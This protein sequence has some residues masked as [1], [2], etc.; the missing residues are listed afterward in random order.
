[1]DYLKSTGSFPNTELLKL[2]EELLTGQFISAIILSHI[3]IENKFNSLTKQLNLS[4]ISCEFHSDTFKILFNIIEQLTTGLSQLNRASIHI[5]TICLRLF[6]THLQ[7]L[8]DLKSN[9]HIDLT[10]YA[11]ADEL[12]KWFDLLLKLTC[13]DNSDEHCMSKEASKALICVIYIQ[14][15]SF[16]ENISSIHQYIIENTNPILVEQCLIEL[17]KNEVL[18]NWIDALRDEN[19]NLTILQS[20][21]SFIDF[22]FSV[23]EKQKSSIRQVLLAFQQLLLSRLINEC[24]TKTLTDTQLQLS[25]LIAQYLNYIF[26]NYTDKISNEEDLFNSILVGLCLMTKINE[27][28]L[29]EVIQPIFTAILP[30]LAEYHLQNPNDEYDKFIISL[31]G[32]MNHILIIGSPQDCLEIKHKDQLKMPIF[33][34][35]Y[36][37]D[38]NDYL[39]NSNLAN[40]SQ[41]RPM[42]EALD[43]KNFLMSI[44]NNIDEGARLLSKLRMFNKNKQRVIQKSIEQQANDAC[45]A[46]FAVY[47]KY[48]RL[49]NLAKYELSRKDQDPPHDQLLSIYDYAN[50]VLTLFS[51]TKARSGDCDELLKHVKMKTLFLL[52]KV[53]E[54]DLIPIIKEDSPS[55]TPNIVPKRNESR[56]Q[57]QRS[58]W[59]KAKH[60]LKLLRHLFQACL[61]FKKL[62]LKKKHADE[63]KY[64]FESLLHTTI[65]NF[66][67]E[68]VSKT[69]STVNNE[70]NQLKIDELEKCLCRQHERALTRLVA[71]RFSKTFVQNV[72]NLKNNDRCL[73]ILSI[74][75][76][77]LIKNDLEW[78]YFNNILASSHQL[79][80]E[81]SNNYSAVI[82]LVLPISLESK[83]ISQKVFYLLNLSYESTDLYHIHQHQ[84]IETLFV[85]F[86]SLIK[87]S[88]QITSSIDLKFISFNWFRLFVLKL[89]E[90]IEI[91]KQKHTFNE[92]LQKQET[93]VFNT[94]I[95]NDLKSLKQIQ[96]KLPENIEE[97]QK[98]SLKYI[99]IDW[100]LHAKE[101]NNTTTISTKSDIE[102]CRNQY[103]ILLLRCGYLY[104][105]VL[106]NCANVDYLKELLHIYYHSPSNP[107]RLLTIKFL[108]YLIPY[109]PDGIDGISRNLIEKFLNDALYL[110]GERNTSL[111]IKV[112]LI[113]MYRNT[114]SIDSSWCIMATEFVINSV[115]S[116]LNLQSIE[117]NDIHQMNKL[118]A[119]LYILGEYIE[120]FRLGSVVRIE[121]DGKLDDESSLGLIIEINSNIKEIE[122]PYMIQYLQTN[123]IEHASIDKLR[124]EIDVSPPNLTNIEDSILDTLGY[125]IQINVSTSESLML[126]Q[127][128]RHTISVL[129][130][131]LTNKKIIETFMNKSYAS[132][133]AKLCTPNLLEN[134][135]QR[136]TG[137]SLYDKQN[138]EKYALILDLHERLKQ[139]VETEKSSMDFDSISKNDQD[140]SSCHI[141]NVGEI[142][143]DPLVV[144]TL[145]MPA[146]KYN[147][148]KPYASETEIAHFKQGRIGYDGI[149][150]VAMP[151]HVVSAEAIQECGTKHR[152]RGRIFPNSDNARTRFPTFIIDNLRLSE[153]NWYYCV[154]LPVGGLVQ[155]GWATNGFSPSSSCGVGDDQYSW[156]YDGSRAV[157]FSEEGFYDQFDGLHWRK[158]DICGCG[159]EINGKNTKI[160]YWLNGKLLGTAFSHDAEIPQS[161]KK[162]NLL[163]NGPA[164]MFFPAVTLQCGG[165]PPRC[166]E[167]IFS[168]EDMQNCPL[169][170]GFKPL[171]LPKH[172]HIENSLVE[173]P[174]SAYLVGENPED[175]LYIPR[176][177]PSITFLRDFVN[178]YHLETIFSLDNHHLIIP[179]NSNG[180][181]L[182][183]TNDDSK[184]LTISFDVELLSLDER[185]NILLF[186]F[187]STEIKVKKSNGKLRCVIIFLAKKCHIKVYINNE[188]RAF[189]D[190]FERDEISKLNLNI[191]PGI[192]AKIQNIAIWKYALSEGDIRRLFTY[193]VSYVAIYYQ[194][195]KE[196]QKQVNTISFAKGQKNFLNEFLIPFNETFKQDVWKKKKKQ[197]DVNESK[198]FKFNDNINYSTIELFGNKTYLVLDKSI[199]QWLE[200]T[201]IL[202]LM[203][204]QWPNSNEKLTLMI[205]TTKSEIYITHEG[206][207]CLE[208]DGTKYES[209]SKVIPGDYFVLFITVQEKSI[210]IYFNEQLEIEMKIDNDEF[211]IKSNSINLFR[212]TDLSK[213]TTNEDKLRISLKSITYL[214]RS[215]SVDQLNSPMLTALPI[216]IIESNLIA[217]GY[218]KSW[219][220]S[221]IKQ[222]KTTNISTVHRILYEQKKQFIK[223]DLE[224]DRKRYFNILSKFNSSM[225]SS[226][227]MNLINSSKFDTKEQIIDIG[228]GIF[229]YCILLQSTENSINDNELILNSDDDCCF[230]FIEDLVTDHDISKWSVDRSSNPCDENNNIYRLLDLNTIEQKQAQVNKNQN[231]T[232]YLRTSIT[233]KEYLTSRIRCEHRLMTIYACDTIINMIKLW[234]YDPSILFPI[235]KFGDHQF[236]VIL[237]KVLHS[238]KTKRDEKSD[239]IHLLINSILK[240]EIKRL[241]EHYD[242]IN[243]DLL[244]SDAPLFYHLQ[245]Y[246]FIQSIEL[247]FKPSLLNEDSDAETSITNE[248]RPDINFILKILDFFIELI[249]D[250][251]LIKQNQF[252][253]IIPILFPIPL[254][255]LMLDLFILVPAHQCK[256]TILRQFSM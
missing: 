30:L 119:S 209:T 169:P 4:S 99:A 29:H 247:L 221:I 165:H 248:Q 210:E 212:E 16:A 37:T 45:A 150:I 117:T 201:I 126:L 158:N 28:F 172:I 222:Y 223:N 123:Q 189:I 26:K 83:D 180:F 105:H 49:I 54:S 162:C 142:N 170:P 9:H 95:L 118:L 11:S 120:P 115:K 50:H 72:L 181:P 38:K 211:Q 21:Y 93:I 124:S 91:E 179:E 148:W 154:R 242:K 65:D 243:N 241:L 152:F 202:N 100:F 133:I 103:L 173:Y 167:L 213:N 87:N 63:Q 145:S 101:T 233:S 14:S 132:A 110:I 146:L 187:N 59:T 130:H 239:Q 104:K 234:S 40:Y 121:A 195:L 237:L 131:M 82:K 240:I 255:N 17:N 92:V 182:S 136:S 160:K 122:K 198:Y 56:Y 75:L 61:R 246:I 48:Y 219:I 18:L 192:A 94:L 88:E 102:F 137:L 193:G 149:F 42:N 71:Y 175:Y 116:H 153:G 125:F 183:I 31:I 249:T 77:Y 256:I 67:Y 188:C 57:R 157:L 194:Q 60:S 114:M 84:F 235:E 206:K 191:L 139:I 168:P 86:I 232:E 190:A 39:L 252:K 108:R 196:H 89:C 97:T 199:Q 96:D 25:S 36:I 220:E 64:N 46:V 10:Q 76:P 7:I 85:S 244:E 230:Q 127:L 236:L 111:E 250:K 176:T 74:Y 254:I 186:K 62:M 112:E 41:Y 214:N 135:S 156:A 35:G 208:N 178:E 90:N 5:L 20:L 216:A 144:D 33:A 23:N 128:K 43:D 238:M 205:L 53:K 224:N 171:L 15:L 228:Q 3:D 143:P 229:P 66:I 218:K 52:F 70:E 80:D 34:G 203:I 68:D 13:N 12:K 1:M 79:K 177:N 184:S 24:E 185:I 140:D 129:Y 109:I 107:T 217:M 231:F 44:Y 19:K 32:K 51:T 98:D 151:C 81:I 6:T 197:L 159:I 174:F 207:L 22:Y 2:N 27:I 73:T 138:L 141:W 251:S 155:I 253:L 78:S 200:Y 69:S 164:T 147:G 227:L 161:S 226:D 166:C 245:K 225:N 106:L 113:Y 58:R 134:T 47:V 8:S 163:P 215:I 204:P 55:T